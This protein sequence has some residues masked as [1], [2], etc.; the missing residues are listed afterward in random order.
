M[1]GQVIGEANFK[2]SSRFSQLI[3]RNLIS[4]PVVAV[5]ELVKNSYDADADNISV[6]FIGLKTDNPELH[7]IDDGIGMSL[8]DVVNKWMIVGTDNKIHSP[9]TE[10]NV[11]N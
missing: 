8:E 10:K 6:E 5:S 9:Y 1:N 4:N 2:F 11:E 3:G 7:I